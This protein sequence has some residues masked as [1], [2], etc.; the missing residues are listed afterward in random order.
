MI[1]RRTIPAMRNTQL[2]KSV[3][4]QV[5]AH[6]AQIGALASNLSSLATT[7]EKGFND[8]RDDIGRLA[9]ERRTNW[10]NIAAWAGIVIV[11]GGGLFAY[12]DKSREKD[13]VEMR[14]NDNHLRELMLLKFQHT[15]EAMQRNDRSLSIR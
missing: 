3:A 10:G 9:M 15:E 7:V 8:L 1:H 11:L 13:Q 14:L 6:D 12:I 2:P 5:A 4:E